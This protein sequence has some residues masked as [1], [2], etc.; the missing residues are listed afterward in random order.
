MFSYE[1]QGHFLFARECRSPKVLERDTKQCP[2][3]NSKSL[4]SLWVEPSNGICDVGA[5][6]GHLG[7]GWKS[8]LFLLVF[9]TH[10]FLALWWLLSTLGSQ[11]CP[12]DIPNGALFS[13]RLSESGS[14]SWRTNHKSPECGRGSV[15]D[16]QNGV[17]GTKKGPKIEGSGTLHGVR[18]WQIWPS[19]PP[20]RYQHTKHNGY[21]GIRLRCSQQPRIV[22]TWWE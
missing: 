10:T 13:P 17:P 5:T 14:F 22:G 16:T 20:R 19:W 2:K 12:N 21:K 3:V 1:F 18:T 15:Y 7:R 4:K 6:L 9:W 11:W 8:I